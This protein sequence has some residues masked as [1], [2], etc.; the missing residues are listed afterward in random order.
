[1]R[2][3]TSETPTADWSK[4][5]SLETELKTVPNSLGEVKASEE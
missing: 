4:S 5:G 3:E 2:R 1:M